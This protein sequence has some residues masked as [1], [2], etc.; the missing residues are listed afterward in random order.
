MSDEKPIRD[1]NDPMDQRAAIPSGDADALFDEGNLVKFPE[2]DPVIDMAAVVAQRDQAQAQV[3]D[4]ERQLQQKQYELD[5]NGGL[6]RLNIAGQILSGYAAAGNLPTLAGESRT[7]AALR[8]ADTIVTD[9]E[10]R[11]EKRA[12]EFMKMLA[13]SPADEHHTPQREN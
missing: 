13:M 12:A 3:R 10:E 2:S 8:H 9:F 7:D 1:T 11:M 6:A 5:L 4:M